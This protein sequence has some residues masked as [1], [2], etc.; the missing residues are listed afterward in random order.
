[1][2]IAVDDPAVV[3]PVQPRSRRTQ[4]RTATA[5]SDAIS[6]RSRAGLHGID[7]S[8]I[9]DRERAYDPPELGETWHSGASGAVKWAP[10]ADGPSDKGEEIVRQITTELVLHRRCRIHLHFD[11][12]ISTRA[13]TERSERLTEPCR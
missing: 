10:R 13:S 8:W 11:R 6:E 12:L 3:D 7:H 9:I 4:L 1:V 2:V 5:R